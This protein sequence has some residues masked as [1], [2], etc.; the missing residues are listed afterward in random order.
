MNSFTLILKSG[1][2]TKEKKLE[3]N[4]TAEQFQA[5]SSEHSLLSYYLLTDS[6]TWEIVDI[7]C[8]A[9]EDSYQ[10]PMGSPNPITAQMTLIKT[11]SS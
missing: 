9:T 8:R 5:F 1:K 4:I 10:A 7:Y 6:V 2:D 11:N 3:T